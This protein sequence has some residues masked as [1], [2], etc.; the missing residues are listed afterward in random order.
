MPECP[1][2]LPY[3]RS[4][5]LLALLSIFDLGHLLVQTKSSDSWYVRLQDCAALKSASLPTLCGTCG[6]HQLKPAHRLQLPS[7]LQCFAGSVQPS[8]PAFLL[9]TTGQSRL[10]PAQLGPAPDCCRLGPDQHQQYVPVLP[11]AADAPTRVSSTLTSCCLQMI[12]LCKLPPVC[13]R[14][15]CTTRRCHMLGLLESNA[16]REG[17]AMSTAYDVHIAK[18]ASS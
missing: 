1:H 16:C 13:K 17:S 4:A 5:V 12:H 7:A 2:G 9:L 10:G 11:A 8:V 15:H 6:L 18:H 14:S 3:F